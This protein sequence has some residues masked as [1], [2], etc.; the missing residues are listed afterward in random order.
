MLKNQSYFEK[1]LAIFKAARKLKDKLVMMS[2]VRLSFHMQ[3]AYQMLEL[4]IL[5]KEVG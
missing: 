5:L 4:A 3:P 1:K 2:F